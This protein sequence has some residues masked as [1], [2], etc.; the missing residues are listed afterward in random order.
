M[1]AGDARVNSLATGLSALLFEATR[2]ETYFARAMDSFIFVKNH[3][4]MLDDLFRIYDWVDSTDCTD[5]NAQSP[6]NYGAFIEG[7]AILYSVRGEESVQT[8]LNRAIS[9]AILQA[10]WQEWT[11]IIAYTKE[12]EENIGSVALVRGL[13]A[14][15]ERNSTSAELHELIAPYLTVQVCALSVKHAAILEDR[16]CSSTRLRNCPDFQA[17]TCTPHN[18]L[19]PRPPPSRAEAKRPLWACC[20]LLSPFRPAIG[21]LHARS[22]RLES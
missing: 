17:R 1:D 12:K 21:T 3:L 8:M 11:G 5:E 22:S 4:M 10:K 9:V 15:Y 14:A 7:L 20:L 13:S 2:N 18:G 19:V 16:P 6:D